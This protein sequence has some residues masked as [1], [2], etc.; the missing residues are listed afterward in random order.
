[1][2]VRKLFTMLQAS[3]VPHIAKGLK[4]HIRLQR[5]KL[6]AD[7][8]VRLNV[9]P[10]N[11]DSVFQVT[12]G[13]LGPPRGCAPAYGQYRDDPINLSARSARALPDQL[14]PAG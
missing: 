4:S 10:L 11:Y 3:S 2:C 7:N 5:C 6:L 14:D 12:K 1:M 8:L 13:G 9:N